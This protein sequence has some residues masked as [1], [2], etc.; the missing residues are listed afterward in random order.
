MP[1][2][3]DEEETQEELETVDCREKMGQ[4]RQAGPDDYPR[5]PTLMRGPQMNKRDI[6]G[7]GATLC[8]V[9]TKGDAGHTEDRRKEMWKPKAERSQ[10]CQQGWGMG[11][12]GRLWGRW[13][14]RE[15]WQWRVKVRRNVVLAIGR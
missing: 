4:R 6:T 15:E 12:M 5:R 9:V 3:I 13:E 10:M 1:W 11:C 14:P 2:R 8:V 7:V